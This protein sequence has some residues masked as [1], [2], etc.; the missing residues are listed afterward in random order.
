MPAD[1]DDL[2]FLRQSELFDNQPE[3]VLQAIYVQ[4]QHLQYGAGDVIFRQ[5]DRGDR[6]YIV[7]TGVLEVAATPSD[8]TEPT[9]I[10]FL[11]PGEVMGEL[12]LL[13]GSARSATVRAPERAEVFALEKATLDDLLAN[14][15]T[16]SRNLCVVLAKRLEA[17][18][19]KLPKTGAKQLQGNLRYF[20]LATVIQTLIGSQQTGILTV[21]QEQGR[22]KVA[23]ILF[24]KGN[25]GRAKV[26]HLTGDDAVFQLFQAPIEGE[27]F[28]QGRS[29]P[30]TEVQGDITMPALSLLMESVRLQDELPVL[31][32]R[33]GDPSRIYRQ[34]A[35]QLRWDDVDTV[36]AA[37]TVW[38]RLKKGASLNDLERDVA[39]CT[40]AIYK[41]ID[42]LLAA[43][44]I[45]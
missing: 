18:T 2:Q 39:R 23:E 8:G 4:G 43:D 31:Q 13:T 40:Y 45:E 11:G 12:A 5:G 41:T 24:I 6:L 25:I 22:H 9:I 17:T 35:T 14:A 37:A 38:A 26:R 36:E 28:F 20:D 29:V 7:K 34:K 44:Q 30:E 21:T 1:H 16:L 32:A 3:A 42:T 19:L 15:P 10:A 27:F 33:L